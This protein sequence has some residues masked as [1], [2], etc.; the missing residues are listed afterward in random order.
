LSVEPALVTHGLVCKP[1]QRL[2]GWCRFCQ[3]GD[4]PDTETCHNADESIKK[5]MHVGVILH[6]GQDYNRT[7]R[8]R[9]RPETVGAAAKN[10][11][12]EQPCKCAARQ[13]EHLKEDVPRGVD[14]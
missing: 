10:P 6:Q 13:A 12:Q 9:R 5:E 4:P 14:V 8:S 3:T 11:Q 2:P 1:A 7:D